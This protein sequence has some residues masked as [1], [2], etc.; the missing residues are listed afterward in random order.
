MN[1]HILYDHGTFTSFKE[2]SSD[3]FRNF[4]NEAPD[5]F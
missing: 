3:H 5:K 1:Y 4:I 2:K